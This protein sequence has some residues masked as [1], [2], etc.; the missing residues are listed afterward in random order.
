MTHNSAVRRTAH[1]WWRGVGYC[2]ELPVVDFMSVEGVF[3]VLDEQACDVLNG[4]ERLL[5]GI[6]RSVHAFT[7]PVRTRNHKRAISHG[8]RTRADI[9]HNL[10]IAMH[11][12]GCIPT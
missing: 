1:D 11:D 7:I 3:S 4:L 2:A 9:V 8:A 6:G 5:D 10:G 12:K